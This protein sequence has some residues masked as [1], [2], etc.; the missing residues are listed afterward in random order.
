MNKAREI[1]TDKHL[2]RCTVGGL[3]PEGWKT[4]EHVAERSLLMV[5]FDALGA[6]PRPFERAIDAV[7]RVGLA[8]LAQRRDKLSGEVRARILIPLAIDTDRETFQKRA[9]RFL[10]WLE[11]ESGTAIDPAPARW[12]QL[13]Y[14][15]AQVADETRPVETVSACSDGLALDL[16]GVP[17]ARGRARRAAARHRARTAC[18]QEV[19]AAATAAEEWFVALGGV[20]RGPGR[21][22]CPFRDD[23]DGRGDAY[24]MIDDRGVRCWGSAHST[25]EGAERFQERLR[26]ANPGAYV[27]WT[28]NASRLRLEAE[29]ERADV[30]LLA[31]ETD[32]DEVPLMA[33][34]AARARLVQV[35]RDRDESDRLLVHV[36]AGAGKSFAMTRD[37]IDRLSRGPGLGVIALPTNASADDVERDHTEHAAASG[38][39]LLRPRSSREVCKLPTVADEAATLGLA[40]R[41]FGACFSCEHRATC[42]RE[43]RVTAAEDAISGGRGAVAVL[44][45]AMIDWAENVDERAIL[46]RPHRRGSIRF[47]YVD[48]NPREAIVA[49]EVEAAE[50]DAFRAA[51]APGGLFEVWGRDTKVQRRR[52]T[53]VPESDPEVEEEIDVLDGVAAGP[54][55]RSGDVAPFTSTAARARALLAGAAGDARPPFTYVQIQGQREIVALWRTWQKLL[56]ARWAGIAIPAV[57]EL[58]ACA[59]NPLIR[60]A[61]V[62]ATATPHPAVDHVLAN[63]RRER[64]RVADT[65]QVLRVWIP[66]G[67]SMSGVFSRKPAEWEASFRKHVVPEVQRARRA[68]VGVSTKAQAEAARAILGEGVDVVNMGQIEGVNRWRDCDVIIAFGGMIPRDPAFGRG[69][70]VE[71]QIDDQDW[72]RRVGRNELAQLFGRA[73]TRS[74]RRP[75]EPDAVRMVCIGKVLPADWAGLP[76]GVAFSWENSANLT[77]YSHHRVR[78]ALARIIALAGSKRRAAAALGVTDTALRK[79]EKGAIPPDRYEEIT[80]RAAEMEPSDDEIAAAEGDADTDAA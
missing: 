66:N 25:R 46:F 47:L 61:D 79:W 45:H 37:L 71:A 77:L 48:E 23:H 80:L 26:A 34:D 24:V 78:F 20:L 52:A 73:R 56:R 4:D 41:S 28:K 18:P 15:Y 10:E 69:S 13:V 17:A 39:A 68:L 74:E 19:V 21:G 75:G 59:W 2:V 12:S 3:S 33:P 72:T 67:Q 65:V 60:K 62:L 63:V 8:H 36:D 5:D 22:D 76:V 51:A 54:T 64:I 40:P 6:D 38:V 57:G 29:E 58:R 30:S 43:M 31:E 35:L 14:A 9:E 7:R 27:R 11:R 53:T 70:H 44:T 55:R 32:E 16:R 49:V 50:L 42:E 1:V